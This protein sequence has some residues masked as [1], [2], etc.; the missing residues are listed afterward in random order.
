VENIKDSRMKYF[1]CLTPVMCL[2]FMFVQ[3]SSSKKLAYELPAE[4]KPEVKAEYAKQCDQGK[5][6]Y[7]L[8]CAK[9]HTVKKHGR[10]IIPDF[11]SDQLRGYELRIT[12]SK[13]EMNL[14]DET[15]S[16]EELGLIMTFLRYKRKNQ[17][18]QN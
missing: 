4:M 17:D 15:V 5:I 6:L 14:T 13:H 11:T 3:C 7:D 10:E 18:S 8:N 1:I 2:L 16:E 12:N 9:C